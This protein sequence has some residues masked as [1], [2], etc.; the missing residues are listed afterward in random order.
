MK[1]QFAPS[2]QTFPGLAG[3]YENPWFRRRVRRNVP[4]GGHMSGLVT[5]EVCAGAG[6]QALGFEQAMIDHA[7]LVEI[8]KG[9]RAHLPY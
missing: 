8:N 2:Q 1:N 9:I 4:T 5:L 3:G 6:G 7:G